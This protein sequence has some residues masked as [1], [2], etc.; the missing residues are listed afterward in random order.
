MVTRHPAGAGRVGGSGDGASV[1]AGVVGLALGALHLVPVGQKALDRVLRAVQVD[2]SRRVRADHVARQADLDVSLQVVEDVQVGLAAQ[3]RLVRR[4]D[5]DVVVDDDEHADD[6]RVPRVGEV[7][8]RHFADRSLGERRLL[9]RRT[10]QSAYGRRQQSARQRARLVDAD[11][12]WLEGGLVLH[13][14]VEER[15]QLGGRTLDVARRHVGV[16][17]VH[18]NPKSSGVRML[19]EAFPVRVKPAYYRIKIRKNQRYARPAS[20]RNTPCSSS[21]VIA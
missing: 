15:A 7:V 10:G 4:R 21:E 11:D 1:D 2:L 17:F 9:L 16:V 20:M 12:G 5:T 18:E 8:T 6:V 19:V 13:D 14:G 3:H